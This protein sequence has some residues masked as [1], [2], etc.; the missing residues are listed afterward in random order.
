MYQEN[1]EDEFNIT[2]QNKPITDHDKVIFFSDDGKYLSYKFSDS[3]ICSLSEIES[4][5]NSFDKKCLIY[6]FEVGN[7]TYY[8]YQLNDVYDLEKFDA[9]IK[10]DLFRLH[11]EDDSYII[12]SAW[13]ICHWYQNSRYCGR[14]GSMLIHKEDERAKQCSK[15]GSIFY[16]TIA[17]VSI[18]GVENGDKLLLTKYS[19]RDYTRYALVAGFIEIGET[20]EQAVK[21]EVM[22]EVGVKV[23]DIRYYASQ[24]WGVSGGLLMGYFATLDGS[25]EITLDTDEL[26][27]AVWLDIEE[28]EKLDLDLKSLTNS[29]IEYWRRNKR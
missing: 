20:P 14:C 21:R 26:A 6:G 24:P 10:M 28:V 3:L 11:S 15:C 18:V 16:P 22:E 19:G 27:E 13:H 29:M 25:P 12:L 17:P 7:D 5:L 2:Y 4:Y 8:I 9:I 1:K 23:K